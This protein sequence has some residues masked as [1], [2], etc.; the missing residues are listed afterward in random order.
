VR[1]GLGGPARW[2][3]HEV[4][5]DQ[6]HRI[7]GGEQPCGARESLHFAHGTDARL[8]VAMIPLAAIGRD[9]EVVEAS[10]GVLRAGRAGADG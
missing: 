3:A 2:H 6:L 5:L 9:H 4:T 8:D 7:Q 10:G 1:V